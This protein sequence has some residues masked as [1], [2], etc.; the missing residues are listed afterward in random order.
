MKIQGE[1]VLTEI[2]DENVACSVGDGKPK[3]VTL[4]E[5]GVM[6]WRLLEAGSTETALAEALTQQFDVSEEQARA[7]AAAFIA[8]LRSHGIL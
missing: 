8:N 4:N 7:D 1:Y 2:G 6:L 5:T 3:V